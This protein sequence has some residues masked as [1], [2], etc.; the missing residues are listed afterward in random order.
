MEGL[1]LGL[2]RAW[3]ESRDHPRGVWSL[4]SVPESQNDI[5]SMVASGTST[6]T[7]VLSPRAVS[8]TMCIGAGQ[9]GT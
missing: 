9:L 6:P 2:E 3:S 4:P 1:G 7:F 5:H 8:E